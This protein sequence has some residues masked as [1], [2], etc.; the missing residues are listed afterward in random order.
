MPPPVVRAKVVP[1]RS[2]KGCI[3]LIELAAAESW[4]PPML[5]MVDFS[6]PQSVRGAAQVTLA[7][8]RGRFENVR[9]VAGMAGIG[10]IENGEY[11]CDSI[12]DNLGRSNN[13]W[14]EKY[15]LEFDDAGSCMFYC[16]KTEPVR[17]ANAISFFGWAN[18][19]YA[20]WLSEKLPR[21]YWIKQADLPPDTVLLIE[22]GLPASI[23]DTLALFWPRDRM[24]CVQPGSGCQ[25]E[26]LHYFSDA[27]DI[28]EP[29]VGYIYRG[30]E[31]HLYPPA[32]AW[33]ASQVKALCSAV[34][35]KNRVYLIRAPGGNGRTIVNQQELIREL[36]RDGFQAFQPETH[37]FASQVRALAGCE[38]AIL[39]SGAAAANL[40][41]MP[42]GSTLVMLIQDNPQMWYWFFHAL[43]AAVGVRLVYHP[44]K[45]LPGTHSVVF[46]WSVEV[47]IDSLRQWLTQN[48]RSADQQHPA[49]P[50]DVATLQSELAGRRRRAMPEMLPAES[51]EGL[52]DV[53]VAVMSYNNAA[54][55]AQTIDSILAQEGV[56]LEVVVYDDSSTDN[57]IEVLKSYSNEPR[58]HFEVNAH[59]L[60]MAGNYNKC[61]AAGRGRYVVVLGSDDLLY[62]GHLS[63]LVEAM[64]ANPHVAL[65]YTQCY[66]IDEHGVRQHYADHPGHPPSSYVGGR[67]EVIDLLSFDNYITPSAAMLRRSALHLVALPEGGI[68]RHDML[69][70]DWEL[71]I[72]LARVAP[73]FVFLRQPSV[74][75][76][77]HGG[78]ISKSFY[79]SDRPLREHTEILEMCLDDA[80]TRARMQGAAQPIWQLYRQRFDAY[81]AEVRAPLQA[82][83]DAIRRA[84][85]EQSN[86]GSIV[87]CLFSVI[88]TTYNRPDL[89]KDALASVG[90]QTLRDFEVILINDNGEPVERLLAAYDFPITYIRQ[91]RNQGLSAAR[92][93]GLAL[94]RGRYV[95]YLDDDDIYLPNHLA[96]LA[97]A[98]EQHPGC[99]VY[100]GVEYVNEKLEDGQRI[101]LGRGQ[102]FRHK[103]FDRDRLFVQNY[104][105]VN[106][107][108]HPREMLAA[109]GEFDTG[110]AAFEDWDMLLRLATR[111]SFVHIPTVTSE[112]HTRV[113]GAGGDHM[114]GRER[115]N[116]PALY[117]ELYA[118]YA[119]SASE[120]LQRGREKMLQ[121]L[122]LRPKS[123]VEEWLSRRLPTAAEK[124]L[125]A[126][127]L[128][129]RQGGPSIGVVV[130]DPEGRSESLRATLDSLIGERCLYP[131]L[132]VWVITKETV[133][134][135][136]AAEN[137]HF[138]T[139]SD[140]PLVTQINHV[141]EAS[142]CQWFM[143]LRAGDELTQSGL[144][145]A[146]LELDRNPECRAVYG[147]Q[148]QRLPDGSLGGVF[149]PGFNLDLLLSFPLVM[150]RHW[151]YRRDLFLAVGGFD[152][153]YPEA[154][155][156]ELLTRLIE[157]EG[158]S[159]LGHIDEPLLITEAPGL[160]DN[161]DER[162][163][164]ERH[165]HNRGYQA[166]VVPGLAARYRIKYGHAMRPLVSI[167]ISTDV[168][169][170]ALQRC[171][172]SL[173]EKT[174]YAHYE[175]LLV[176]TGTRSDVSAWLRDVAAL[177]DEKVRVLLSGTGLPQNL[178]AQQARGDYLL[179][180]SGESA[181]VNPDWLDELLNHALRPEVGVVGAKLLTASGRIAQAGLLLGVDGVATPA[182]AGELMEAA[183]YFNRLQVD[184]NYSAVSA[185]CLMIRTA[186]FAEAG[187]FDEKTSS[188]SD[189]DLCLKVGQ[190]G[191][192]VVW[193]PHAVVMHE[194]GISQK[195]L[196]SGDQ[197]AKRK[198]C[199]A[200]R[201]T[202]YEKWLPQ[203]AHD[204]AYNGNLA[205][206]GG[207]FLL[208]LNVGLTWRPLSWRPLPVVLAH[209][210]DPWGC[211]NYRII[212][213]FEALR[214]E[215]LVD[216]TL[217]ERLLNQPEL[218]RF[219]PDV[220]V[221]QRQTNPTALEL[222]AGA[223][224]FSPAFKIYE[225]D[226]YLPNTPMKSVHRASM[227][228]DLVRL[229]RQGLSVVDRFVVSTHALADQFKGYHSRIH[230]VENR[231]PLDWWGNLVL[232]VN[233][234]ARPRVGW[235]GGV[236][237]QGDLE[238]I[239]DVVRDLASEVDWV[240]F[241]MCPDKL[242]PYVA[243]FHPGVE[244]SSYPQFLANLRLDLAIAPLED[245]VFNACKSNLRLLEYGICGFPV[246]ASDIVSYR[247]SLPVTLVKNRYRDW[248][249]AIRG[250][251][252]ERNA[253]RVEGQRLQTAV[254][255]EWMLS[256]DNLKLWQRAWLPD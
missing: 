151:L 183:G 79:S 202:V 143:L 43:A 192:L 161:P 251:L 242:R 140:Q 207:G 164:I 123:D 53:T 8:Y 236:G 255:R 196:E 124:R 95:V 93:A 175:L 155:E 32:I 213:P 30:D 108:A 81:P 185:A 246:I 107:W 72:R 14:Y 31:Y 110:L 19:N 86:H 166:Q 171:S 76:R 226:D 115:K 145:V 252:A 197:E 114:L 35:G 27:A 150:A 224:R 253:L 162:R 154:F 26:T 44:V 89:L 37:D 9:L 159:G 139:V 92:N 66:W 137:L 153:E 231:L 11:I 34:E 249:E 245:N 61:V 85:L 225:L 186:I 55:L 7:Q 84:L 146:A 241:G 254:K 100:T 88:L 214:V 141:I 87:S 198:T 227:S 182:F 199:L 127:Y 45:G 64:D 129:N 234:G 221:F 33:M 210:A 206:N 174:S 228:K 73:D 240:F 28:W 176:D 29:R 77:V 2:A 17:V 244:I 68:H 60:G 20:H 16:G 82:R 109:V 222:M 204:P 126:D 62:P 25:V 239:A 98:F 205:L 122:G 24:L 3:E 119:G 23:M 233:D 52:V 102:P 232:S 111:Y 178:A 15:G 165:L 158:L 215:G 80:P 48:L 58:L 168:P 163:V 54:F 117:R 121:S 220:I 138:R 75:Y 218:A 147:D 181:I 78:Q 248:V 106:T 101:E 103:V 10:D 56:Q 237:H 65:G 149:L 36:S 49:Q 201:D 256:G 125:I 193:T 12:H 59:N 247:G 74:G 142:D 69:A 229:L 136:S 51:H 250:A 40:L 41:W 170:A 39:G 160:C 130:L 190:Q 6:L 169:L 1:V 184:Q 47:P 189:V 216:G 5:E 156:F 71:W 243:E 238:M 97:E 22:A 157:Q 120:G 217:S 152:S 104:I 99:V 200:E 113:P 208:E 179:F 187:G 144:L 91:G 173:L 57:S 148:L 194:S 4:L 132:H 203:L 50:L 96:V 116:F 70:G 135:T 188:F 90:S 219:S 112:V 180:L 67:D 94:A 223:K 211:G 177:N 105:P 195:E 167:I 38:L 235:A 118:R 83:I 172:E 133:S 134:T 191:Y 42:R 128:D 46:H 131:R 13:A 212:K 63:S 21:F 230:V 209:N 18:Y